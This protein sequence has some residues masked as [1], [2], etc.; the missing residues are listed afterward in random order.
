MSKKGFTI[1]ETMATFLLISTVSVLLFELFVSLQQMYNRG[2][3]Q[4]RLL[5]NTANFQR[6]IEQ[7]LANSSQVTIENCGTNCVKF[8]LD[9]LE[10]NLKIENNNLIYDNYAMENVSGSK[11]GNITY[12]STPAS[13]SD[14]GNAT[15]ES[16]NIPITNKI[17][18][19]DF[20]IHII[21]QIT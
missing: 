16:I 5:I 1:V 8:T 19:K 21:H 17:V 9:G 2:E 15:I 12:K 10:K 6:R 7:D 14:G 13:F 18:S 4:T 3:I 20:G 11:L